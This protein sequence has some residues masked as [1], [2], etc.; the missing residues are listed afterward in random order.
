MK[1]M[2]KTNKAKEY[3]EYLEYIQTGSCKYLRHKIA[4]KANVKGTDVTAPMSET[5]SEK[6]GMALATV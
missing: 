6:K 4:G 1:S 5:R 2:E 3:T